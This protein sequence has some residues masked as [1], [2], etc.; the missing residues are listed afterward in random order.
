[1][2]S[3]TASC[4]LLIAG[5]AY[6][7]QPLETETARLLPA[8]V[9]KIE[10]TGEYQQ[11]GD[12]TERALPLVFEYG[13]T[14]RTEVAV[15]PV[16][17]TSIQPKVGRVANGVGDLEITITHL[18]R[19]EADSLPAFALAGE[20]KL[21]TAT[22]RQ[23][24]TGK[25]DLTAWGI[26]SQRFG[27]MDVHANLGY[28]IVGQPAG[29]RLKNVI[30]F[31]VASELHV[32][33]RFDVVGELIGNT[34]STGDKAE[35]TSGSGGTL[36]SSEAPSGETSAMAG[37]RWHLSSDVIVSMGLSYDNNHALLFR[38]GVTWRFGGR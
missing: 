26:A 3:L 30:S 25:T 1:M 6:A 22:N 20:V 8:G 12:G 31:A 32:S 27:R 18:L 13:L 7:S 4:L 5:A 14:P 10:L 9:F 34:S 35:G 24:G 37:V 29:T 21:P 36:I 16:F 17:A 38:P 19:P 33:P 15:E 28:T 23:I 2:R 11:S